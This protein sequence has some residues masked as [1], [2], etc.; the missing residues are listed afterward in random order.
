MS[1]AWIP[2]VPVPD[3]PAFR[4]VWRT[5]D[6]QYR[7]MK[8]RTASRLA[9]TLCTLC[10]LLVAGWVVLLVVHYPAIADH[11]GWGYLI[12]GR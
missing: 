11:G 3:A 7:A 4:N 12:R 9:W 5:T 8:A 1:G 2:S 10:V 6:R